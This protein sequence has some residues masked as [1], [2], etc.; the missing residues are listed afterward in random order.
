MLM[1][2]CGLSQGEV[3]DLAERYAAKI[4]SYR[5]FGYPKR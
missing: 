5:S 4:R 2:D 3:L 1:L